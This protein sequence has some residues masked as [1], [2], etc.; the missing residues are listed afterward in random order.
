MRKE[1]FTPHLQFAIN[2]LQEPNIGKK[3]FQY[4]FFLLSILFNS[5]KHFITEFKVNK[6]PSVAKWIYSLN[7]ISSQKKEDTM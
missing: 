5:Y 2:Q 1:M 4:I 7:Y 3:E 6:S